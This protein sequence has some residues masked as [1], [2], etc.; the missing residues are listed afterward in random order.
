MG[1]HYVLV[2]DDDRSIRR[3][4]RETLRDAGYE[5]REARDGLE[6]LGLIA[7]ARPD[8]ML[9]DL[10]MPGMNGWALAA[11]LRTRDIDVPTVVMTGDGKAH[12]AAQKLEACDYLGKPFDEDAVLHAVMLHGHRWRGGEPVHAVSASGV[13]PDDL[14]NPRPTLP[15]G[16]HRPVGGHRPPTA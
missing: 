1:Q 5:V 9:L 11:E 14:S 7:Q 2:V 12:I 10:R 3:L 13:V 16:Y 8:V 4:V 15:R 6:A